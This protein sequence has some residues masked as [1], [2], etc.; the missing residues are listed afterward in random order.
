MGFF[1]SFH[2]YQTIEADLKQY[3]FG[4]YIIKTEYKTNSILEMTSLQNVSSFHGY[5]VWIEKFVM[6]ATV[7]HHDT[8][9]VKPNSNL[10]NGFFCPQ[11][12]VMTYFFS[13]FNV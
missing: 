10:S 9:R 8:C 11:L 5:E 6:K 3:P 13:A 2:Q 12:I 4:T 1:F 7:C